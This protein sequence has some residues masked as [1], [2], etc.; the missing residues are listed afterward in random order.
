[1]CLFYICSFFQF[2]LQNCFIV[3]FYIVAVVESKMH[4]LCLHSINALNKYGNSVTQQSRQATTKSTHTHTH[5]HTHMQ[6]KHTRRWVFAICQ[7]VLQ[8]YCNACSHVWLS[9]V[10]TPV[11][12]H[13]SVSA[14]E[15]INSKWF[16]LYV[17]D[18]D[19][20]ALLLPEAHMFV[21]SFV[22]WNAYIIIHSAYVDLLST[23]SR[24]L[25][26][27]RNVVCHLVLCARVCLLRSQRIHIT[28]IV[29]PFSCQV[30]SLFLIILTTC[31]A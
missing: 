31:T 17:G 18:G 9:I 3:T 20:R 11:T 14:F 4:A 29:Q 21:V 6:P 1:M 15:N 26:S 22:P 24:K 12:P 5:K 27:C 16:D 10:H 25:N 13:H 8:V 28:Y 30:S 19:A 7:Q 2:S 23:Y